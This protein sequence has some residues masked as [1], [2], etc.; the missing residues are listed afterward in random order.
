VSK[1]ANTEVGYI[2]Q[3]DQGGNEGHNSSGAESLRG[4]EKSPNNVSTTF[5]NT[6]RC[7]RNTSGSNIG[8]PNLLLTPGAI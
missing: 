4:V 8:A 3:F 6:V 7:F 2:F 5:F 1:I